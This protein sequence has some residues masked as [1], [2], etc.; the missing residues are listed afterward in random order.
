MSRDTQI[1]VPIPENES[2]LEKLEREDNLDTFVNFLIFL[3][4]ASVFF[5]LLAIVLCYYSRKKIPRSGYAFENYVYIDLAAKT[6]MRNNAVV[7]ACED[8]IKNGYTAKNAPPLAMVL[9][10]VSEI[11]NAESFKSE[12]PADATNNVSN[13]AMTVN[14]GYGKVAPEGEEI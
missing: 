10:D 8:V 4:A 14:A 13:S 9:E 11:R 7:A 3:I 5:A 12:R 6:E 1:I 2:F